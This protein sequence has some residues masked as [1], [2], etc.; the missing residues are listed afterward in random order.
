MEEKEIVMIGIITAIAA[1]GGIVLFTSKSPILGSKLAVTLTSSSTSVPSNSSVTIT[2][3]ATG[4]TPPYTYSFYQVGN[5]APMVNTSN[6]FAFAF[7]GYVGTTGFYVVVTDSAGND[8]TSNTVM[9]AVENALSPYA[10]KT[11]TVIV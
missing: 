11:Y 9:F 2:A 4:G 8:A 1:L 7:N 10:S 3:K 6:S 5:N